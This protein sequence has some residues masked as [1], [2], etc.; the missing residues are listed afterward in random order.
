M[1]ERLAEVGGRLLSCMGLFVQGKPVEDPL[2]FVAFVSLLFWVIGVAAG[3]W[4]ARHNHFA[5][6]ALPAGIGLL[7]VQAYDHYEPRRMW[8]L[9]TYLLFALLLL[10]RLYYLDA[11]AVWKR[12]RVFTTSDTELDVSNGLMAT[13]VLIVVVAWLLPVSIS[14]M[15]SAAHTWDSITRPFRERFSNAVSALES[16]YG[17][18][19]RGDFYGEG[20]SLGRSGALGDAIV[21]TVK[22]NTPRPPGPRYYWRGRVYDTY[23]NGQW[24]LSGKVTRDHLP[25]QDAIEIPEADDRTEV[26]L[27]FTTQFPSERLLYAPAQPIWTDQTG[28][29]QF[30]QLPDEKSDPLAWQ[31]SP[32]LSEGEHYQVRAAIASPSIEDLRLSGTDYPAWVV[33]RYLQLPEAVAPRLREQAALVTLGMET[34]YDKAAAITAFLRQEISY[35]AV[36]DP[37]PKGVDPVLWVL[38]DYKKGFCNYYASA[39]VLMLRSLGIPARLAVGFAQGQFDPNFRI[40]T[41]KKKDAHAWPEVYFEG[42][43]WVE[44]EPTGNQDPL[45]RPE[46][47]GGAAP[48]AESTGP[49]IPL[50]PSETGQDL[51]NRADE[52]LAEE[53]PAPLPFTRTPLGRGLLIGL[54]LGAV[55]LFLVLNRRYGLIERLPVYLKSNYERQGM[56]APGWIERWARWMGLTPIQRSFEAVNVSL[57]WLSAPQPV[58][59]TAAQRARTLTGVLPS[60]AAAIEALAF[61]HQ[62]ALFTARPADPA[63]ARRAGWSILLHA[64]RARLLSAWARLREQIG[65]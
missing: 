7:I 14:S 3:Y 46:T 26:R 57:Y 38:F 65:L 39:E 34:P 27:T 40:Y 45:L 29:L 50:G 32:P 19:G 25:G 2:F 35:Q 56:P 24:S 61:E 23:E 31:A 59:A 47:G 8:W 41:V 10:G 15:E 16:P 22:V 18:G 4:L 60:A 42:I 21:F 62:T 30:T 20:L 53:G 48:Q 54:P 43:G 13:A 58:H 51:V 63:R 44:F 49:N 37:A 17:P 11:R 52:L 9:A 33:G 28:T 1:R 55:A 12:R 36:L 6:A 5:A 64:T